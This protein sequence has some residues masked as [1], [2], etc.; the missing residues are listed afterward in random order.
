MNDSRVNPQ[1]LKIEP[2]RNSFLNPHENLLTIHDAI[3]N[4]EEKN[5]RNHAYEDKA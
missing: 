4:Q 3:A 5:S 1:M 2:F